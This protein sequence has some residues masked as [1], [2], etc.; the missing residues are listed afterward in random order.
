MTRMELLTIVEQLQPVT[1]K[2]ITE[3]LGGTPY[4]KLRINVC[5]HLLQDQ[6][7]SLLKRVRIRGDNCAWYEYSLAKKG[8]QKLARMRERVAR[9][10]RMQLHGPEASTASRDSSTPY[11]P[12]APPYDPDLPPVYPR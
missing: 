6:K 2:E 4:S 3:F 10:I 7:V 11:E 9:A 8:E 12:P 5:V 1:S